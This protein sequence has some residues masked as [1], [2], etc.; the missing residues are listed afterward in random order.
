MP[1]PYDYTV[2]QP[3]VS[4]YFDAMRQG[5]ADR[6]T[7]ENDQRMNALAKYLPGALEGDKDQQALAMR[8]APVDQMA[9]LKDRFLAMDAQSLATLRQ[10]Q[11]RAASLAQWA[12]TPEKWAVANAEIKKTMPNAPDLPFEQRGMVIAQAQTVAEQLKQA[13]DEKMLAN[14]TSRTNAQN[15][16]TKAQIQALRNKPSGAAGGFDNTT[17][18][19]MSG[20]RKEYVNATKDFGVVNDA[21]GRIKA[22]ANNATPAGDLSMIYAYM[23]MLDP[24][25]V[26]RESEFALAQNAKPLLDRLGIS[27]DAVKSAWEGTK[28]QP[29]VRADFLNQ[30]QAL[31][32]QQVGQKQQI[33]AQY[34][35]LATRFGFDPSLIVTGRS[36]LQSDT[37]PQAPPTFVRGGAFGLGEQDAM[38]PARRPAQPAR[39]QQAP[40]V[41]QYDAQGRRV[42]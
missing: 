28:L 14:D 11:T 36:A 17:F 7:A 32:E 20:L 40:S 22:T 24:G 41:I 9:G 31:Y 38:P 21:Y 29:Q 18:D 37:P 26:V 16:L 30:A 1:T 5:R 34:N 27:W 13:H 39:P 15:A 19:N 4:T 2:A 12:D 42:R 33:D 25:S 8:A 3:K 35:E 23:K 10:N 6:L